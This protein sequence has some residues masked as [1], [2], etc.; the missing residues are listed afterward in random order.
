MATPVHSLSFLAL[1]IAS[2]LFAMS[3]AI[4]LKIARRKVLPIKT[5]CGIIISILLALVINGLIAYVIASFALLSNSRRT[6]TFESIISRFI[7][8]ILL[9]CL[10]WGG[11]KYFSA[12]KDDNDTK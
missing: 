2:C 6:G 5:R 3:L 10:T 8:V 11:K 7:P 12:I 4:I 9:G 1:Y